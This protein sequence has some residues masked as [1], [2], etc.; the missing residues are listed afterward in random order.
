MPDSH[1][2]LV[3]EKRPRRT[4]LLIVA[5]VF[6]CAAVCVAGVGLAFGGGWH[7]PEVAQPPPPTAPPA[8]PPSM[9]PHQP[10]ALPNLSANATTAQAVRVAAAHIGALLSGDGSGTWG[11]RGD[12]MG[13]LV[14]LEFHDSATFDGVSGGA[15]GCVDLA[16]DDNLGLQEAVDLLAPVVLSTGA[17]LSRADVWALAANIMIEAAGGPSLEY[18]VGRADSTNC[19]GHGSR[20]VSA[21]SRCAVETASVFVHR[22]GFTAAETVALI[23]AHVLGA[24]RRANSGY[25]GKWVTNNRRFSNRYF[26]DLLDEPW[27]I[28]RSHNPRFG[29]RT[30]WQLLGGDGVD[31][32]TEIMLQTDVDLAFDTT[33]AH[34]PIGFQSCNRVGGNPSPQGLSCPRA[35]HAFSTHVDTFARSE[36]AFFA[37]FATAWARLT[38]MN[39]PNLTCALPGCRTPSV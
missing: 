18:R 20:H 22:L 16:A 34:A 33:G 2:L 31:L 19:T 30:R 3:V 14:R 26:R 27:G 39:A 12:L 11:D 10:S 35:R 21:E 32:D 23:G 13:L 6:G 29:E 1:A 37:T 4:K 9:P 24:A 7:L 36:A 8:P 15:D 17:L 28:R 5:V 25:E 38:A